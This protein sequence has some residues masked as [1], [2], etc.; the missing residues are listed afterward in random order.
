MSIFNRYIDDLIVQVGRI[1]ATAQNNWELLDL[2]NLKFE[3]PSVICLS[4][5]GAITNKHA[6]RLAEQVQRF[7]DLLFKT[8]DGNNALDHVD[9]IGVKYALLDISGIGT[10]TKTAMEQFVNA[11]LALLVDANGNKLELT[12]AQQNMSRLTFFTYCAGNQE[13]QNIMINLNEKL[14]L[15]GYDQNEIN[16]INQATLEISFAPLSYPLNQIPSVHVMSLKD[17]LMSKFL[18]GGF[19][20]ITDQQIDY[21][22]GVYLHQVEPGPLFGL[23]GDIYTAASIQ[24]LSTSLLNSYNGEIDEHSIRLLARENDWSIRKTNID[25][26]GHRPLNADCVSQI[27]A[28]AL[29]KGVENSIQNFR[30][31][32]YVPNTYWHELMA[33]FKSIINHYGHEKLAQNP[34]L[35]YKKRKSKFNRMR[36]KQ[37]FKVFTRA[38]LPTYEEMIDTLNNVDSWETAITYLQNNNFFGVE[39]VLPAV[40]V[41]TQAEKETILK[42][43]D[44][45]ELIIPQSNEI[46][47]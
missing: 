21:L 24:V 29:C 1:N 5:N 12:K 27:M 40:Q 32:K 28:W 44:K 6:K 11:I 2:E 17:S 14:A 4:G 35:M 19:G 33:D 37:L 34:S 41:L 38:G 9:I 8:K 15:A 3:K 46:E 43:A 20:S 18:R 13:L 23:T 22:D 31:D 45:A 30:A 16:A 36:V 47:I 10:F 7:L 39:H 42:M 26:M 25:G